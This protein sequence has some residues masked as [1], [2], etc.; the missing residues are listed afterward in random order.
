[1]NDSNI[2]QI[3][4]RYEYDMLYSKEITTHPKPPIQGALLSA[5]VIFPECGHIGS[6]F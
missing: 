3:V 5:V 2:F 6:P 4:G 1:M